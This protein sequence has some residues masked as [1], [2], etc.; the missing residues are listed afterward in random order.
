MSYRRFV[1]PMLAALPQGTFDAIVTGD[2]VSHGKPHPEPY[3]KA[4]RMLRVL[5]PGLPGGR[6]LQHR[7]PVGRRRGCCV[8]VVPN[9]V[10]VVPGERRVFRPSLGAGPAACPACTPRPPPAEPWCTAG[11]GSGGG[12]PPYAGQMSWWLQN[13]QA[14][15]RL[16]SHSPLS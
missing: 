7:N 9:H 14:R 5:A 6:G 15:Q 11:A 10:P 12:V 16:G 4:T 2:A 8:L 1:A 13:V 3:L